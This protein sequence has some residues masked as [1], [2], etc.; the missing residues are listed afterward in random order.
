MKLERGRELG[1]RK[2]RKDETKGRGGERKV[3][4]K[5]GG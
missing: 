3:E 5:G 2:R 1:S 4:R